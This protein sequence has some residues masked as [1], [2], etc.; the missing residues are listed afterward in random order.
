[1]FEL[2]NLKGRQNYFVGDF[3][4]K[5]RTGEKG[6]NKGSHP[7]ERNILIDAMERKGRKER[8]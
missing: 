6:G 3:E 7:T 1:M 8:K 4:G 5:H 2:V